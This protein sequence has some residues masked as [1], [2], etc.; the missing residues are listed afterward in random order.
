MSRPAAAAEAARQ[1]AAAS[2]RRAERA[3]IEAAEDERRRDAADRA[4]AAAYAASALAD[5]E[6]YDA[7]AERAWEPVPVPLPTYV[8]APK[9]PRSVRIIDL[10]VPGAW[11]SG[12]LVDSPL[13]EHEEHASDDA[14][15]RA[16][17]A[18]Y[19]ASA[20]ADPEFYDAVAERAWEPVPVPLPTYVSAPKAPRSVRIIDLSVPGAWTSGRLADGAI[21]EHEEHSA[22]DAAAEQAA[23]GRDPIVTGE[24]LVERRRAVGD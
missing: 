17:A 14:A 8:S 11:T 16:G 3:A 12:R 19:A 9:A 1:A 24:V 6:F 18:A 15:D 10:S 5:P 21:D 23:S 22:D 2:A 13:D 20:L 7:V 4:G